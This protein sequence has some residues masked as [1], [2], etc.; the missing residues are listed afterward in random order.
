MKLEARLRAFAAF[1]RQRS[2]SGAAEEL[3]ISQPAVSK[4]ISELESALGVT[5]VDR[6][7]RDGALTVAGDFLANYVVRAEALL[8][9][10]S[11]GTAQYRQD[12]P[13][14]VA[15]VASSLTGRYVLPKIIADFR[16]THPAIHVT[17]HVANAREAV[18][19]LRTHQAELGFIAGNIVAPE[20]EAEQLLEYEVVIVAKPALVPRHPS[21]DILE[22]LTWISLE[23]GAATRIS[24]DEGLV[25]LGIMPRRRLEL[26][27]I[28]AVVH[29]V[30]KGY[31]ISAIS[32]NIVAQ[33]LDSGAFSIIRVRGWN[34]WNAVSL[35]SVRDATLTPSAERF[36]KFV[37]IRLKEKAGRQSR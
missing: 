8:A 28:E 4:H 19:R 23:E 36:Q 29:A 35:L 27:S 17:M 9:Q 25:R 10:A 34:V 18:E 11:I 14:S 33:E 5:L 24:S 20:I 21:R 13:G 2:F 22:G 37:R 26:P 1:V 16:H 30:E 31:G 12:G 15:I 6:S 7:R 3:R 32:R